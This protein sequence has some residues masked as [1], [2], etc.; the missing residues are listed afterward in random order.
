MRRDRGSESMRRN[1]LELL[2]G[3]DTAQCAALI[4]PYISG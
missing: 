3:I 4:A 2:R 1:A